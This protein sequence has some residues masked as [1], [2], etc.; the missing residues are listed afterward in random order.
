VVTEVR[1]GKVSGDGGSVSLCG[2]DEQAEDGDLSED[3]DGGV[4]GQAAVEVTRQTL[5]G[6]QHARYACRDRTSPPA[7]TQ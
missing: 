4:D 7:T 2:N 6:H 1:G 3:D 5:V